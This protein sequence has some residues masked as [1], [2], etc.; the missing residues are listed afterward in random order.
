MYVESITYEAF[1]QIRIGQVTRLE[2]NAVYKVRCEF[3]TQDIADT[4]VLNNEEIILLH[5][6]NQQK[7]Q[8]TLHIASWESEKDRLFEVITNNLNYK[9]K[10][11]S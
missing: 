5:V 9:P 4:G 1:I 7:G 8:C 11:Q 2:D 3:D 6:D 10:R